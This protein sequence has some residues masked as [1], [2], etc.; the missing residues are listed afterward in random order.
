MRIF[1]LLLACSQTAPYHDQRMPCADHDPLRKA[2]FGELHSHTSYSFDAYTYGVRAKPA[3]AYAF[4]RGEA[5]TLPSPAAG[6]TAPTVRLSRPLDFAA[7]TDH[8]EYL[9]EVSICTTPGSVAYDSDTCQQY[10][11]GMFTQLGPASIPPDPV[12]ADFCGKDHEACRA[13]AAPV[14]KDI[15]DAAENAYDRSSDCRFTTFIAYE[16]SL[17]P[18]G[19]NMHRNVIFRNAR[20]LPA[21]ISFYEAVEPQDLWQ[22]LAAQ[23]LDAGTGCDVIA[24][25]H[26]SNASNGMLFRAE[27]PDANGLDGERK[28]AQ[29]RARL[30]P[31][32]EI[33]Q[34][35][36]DS[37]CINGLPEAAA[38]PDELCDF[39]KWQHPPYRDCGPDGTGAGGLG[40]LGCV[41]WR[42]Y[43]RNVLKLGLSEGLRLGVN[44][45]KL[46]IIASTDTH[47][48]TPGNVDEASFAGHTGNLDDSPA[49]ML[50]GASLI[51][52]RTL[53]NPGGLAAVWAEENSRDSIFDALKRR[54][55]F[56][57]SGPRISVR[58]FGG[59][60][61]DAALCNDPDLVK[62]GYAGGVP[63]GGDLPRGSASPSFVVAAMADETPLQKLQIVKG[64][65]DGSGA[66]QE[67]VFDVVTAGG[68]SVDTTS[69]QRSAG[70]GQMQLCG[71]FSDPSFDATRPAFWYA[72][73]VENPSCRWSTYVCS[74]LSAADRATYGCDNLPQTI[75][76]RAWT[77]P[78]WYAPQ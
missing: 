38:A 6:G 48:G 13:A 70:G 42:D 74:T 30:E 47:S 31:L 59:W 36:G 64:W 55:T 57:T 60:S 14:W 45:F 33:L 56:G 28:Q 27:Y 20:A 65:V 66:L 11:Q 1:L 26:N 62:K 16:Y 35:K 15:I 2:F 9:G 46:G 29:L 23:C 51:G 77:S 3:D 61:Y 41:S 67:Q 32:V 10:R 44:P 49:G 37:E 75:Q 78:I 72:R 52:D 19:A 24:I 4:A 5:M 34:H 43:V 69:C 50:A 54:E 8:S 40:Q 7:V 76:E 17:S 71:V 73:V 39:E 53:D 12:S 18:L 68:G 22:Q 63:M 21:P 25:P 58:F